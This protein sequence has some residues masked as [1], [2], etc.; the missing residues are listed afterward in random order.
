M[1]KDFW[2]YQ[3]GAHRVPWALYIVYEYSPK[4]PERGEMSATVYHE[5]IPNTPTHS[6]TRY[7]MIC[8]QASEYAQE[9]VGMMAEAVSGNE[10]A[11]LEVTVDDARHIEKR[12]AE[13]MQG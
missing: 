3:S 13:I 9:I 5:D 7:D 2:I 4:Y 8:R 10:N 12:I 1:V 6:F 11:Q